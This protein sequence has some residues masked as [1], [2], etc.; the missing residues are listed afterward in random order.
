MF[1]WPFHQSNGDAKVFWKVEVVRS[2]IKFGNLWF[3][4]CTLFC[5][6]EK[7]DL[8]IWE[9]LLE[10]ANNIDAFLPSKAAI[11]EILKKANDWI[12]KA[13]SLMVNLQN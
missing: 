5:C 4:V 13:D 2:V 9:E 12:S 7:Q 11:K 6:R 1:F 8:N 3:E 10:E